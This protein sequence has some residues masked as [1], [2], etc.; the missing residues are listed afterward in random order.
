MGHDVAADQGGEV[1]HVDEGKCGF[2]IAAQHRSFIH[3]RPGRQLPFDLEGIDID[4]TSGIAPV[5][6]PLELECSDAA[7]ADMANK[8]RLLKGFAGCDFMRCE[9]PDWVAFW[10]D[11]AP[12][13]S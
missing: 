7:L 2:H 9:A 3:F 5:P 13:A 6:V 8:A 11:P 10:N 1:W 4:Q 12:A